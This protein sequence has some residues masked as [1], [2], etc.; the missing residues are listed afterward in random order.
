[1]QAGGI[2]LVLNRLPLDE[3]KTMY[4]KVLGTMVLLLVVGILLSG[5]ATP[6]DE[7]N[8]AK[9]QVQ[10]A[11]L[12]YMIEHSGF[13]I[14]PHG[15][16]INTS[17]GCVA[18]VGPY[19]GGD[20]INAGYVLDL[21]YLLEYASHWEHTDFYTNGRRFVPLE[22]PICCYGQSREEGTN[23]YTG[24]CTNP[25]NGHYVWLVDDN[26]NVCSVCVGDDCWSNNESGYQGVWP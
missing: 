19:P 24:N 21:C 7:Y 3:E 17:G 11:V 13:L 20:F 12:G 4:K 23:F 2:R 18:W 1:M 22:L 9:D 25:Y 15:Y 8:K 10:W 6:E 16:M 26:G 5:C 14:P